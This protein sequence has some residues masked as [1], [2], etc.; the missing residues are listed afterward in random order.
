MRVIDKVL[1]KR[2]IVV[3]TERKYLHLCFLSS[4]TCASWV[5]VIDLHNRLEICL[6]GLLAKHSVVWAE[7]PMDS[8]HFPQFNNKFLKF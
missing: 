7:F 1:R 8:F 5:H 4:L 2:K 6:Q 3:N